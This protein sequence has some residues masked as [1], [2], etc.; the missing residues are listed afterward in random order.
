MGGAASSLLDE[1]KCTY[2]RGKTEATIKNFSPYYSRQYSVAFCNHVRSEV[3]QQ[4]DLTSQFLKTKVT[5]GHLV[6][7]FSH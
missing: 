2:I 7:S 5:Y 3:E 6:D 1:G 4:R